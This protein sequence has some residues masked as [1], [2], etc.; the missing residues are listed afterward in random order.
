MCR[1][2]D[3]STNII[4]LTNMATYDSEEDEDDPKP[5]LDL[6]TDGE[7]RQPSNS[8]IHLYVA[9]DFCSFNCAIRFGFEKSEEQQREARDQACTR[10]AVS[11]LRG[12]LDDCT[13]RRRV[14]VLSVRSQFQEES[15]FGQAC[16]CNTLDMRLV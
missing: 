7:I 11:L 1:E 10:Y 15:V 13:Q 12:R 3:D 9:N 8:S 14:Q 6:D 2:E 4:E 16:Y 5:E